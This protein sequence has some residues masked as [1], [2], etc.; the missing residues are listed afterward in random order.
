MLA[1]YGNTAYIVLGKIQEKFRKNWLNA[2]M[3]DY[4]REYHQYCDN[5][6]NH[7]HWLTILRQSWPEP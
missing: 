2:I 1:K 6:R 4:K 5:T 3:Q 7:T